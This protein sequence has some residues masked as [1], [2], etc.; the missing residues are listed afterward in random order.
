MKKIAT[1]IGSTTLL[2]GLLAAPAAALPATGTNTDTAAK[3]A[4]RLSLIKSRGDGEI[5]RRLSTLS[6]LGGRINATTKLSASDKATLVAEVDSTTNGLNTLKTQLDADTTLD[7]AHTDAQSILNE[8]RVYALVRPKIHLI[9]TADG[10]QVVE[11]KLT[12]L[13]GKLQTR[14]ST[15]KTTGKD[16]T[17]LQ[18]KLDDMTKQTAAAQS[19]SSAVQAAVLPLQPSD[20]NADHGILAGYQA[21]LSKAHVAIEAAYNDAQAVITGLKNL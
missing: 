14:L 19:I 5:T 16:V 15:A 18:I 1:I 10:Q 7:A 4:A 3:Q 2:L 12:T 20:F 9:I 11:G 13:A 17:S 21:Q 6:N 8:Y